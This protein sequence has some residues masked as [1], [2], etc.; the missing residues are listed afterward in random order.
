MSVTATKRDLT[1]VMRV[2]LTAE[3]LLNVFQQGMKLRAEVVSGLP[4]DAVIVRHFFDQ[5]TGFYW[6]TVQSETF[7]SIKTGGVIPVLP[8]VVRDLEPALPSAADLDA[9]AEEAAIRE[10]TEEKAA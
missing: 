7:K 6:L 2:P 8:I 10:A 3:I 4:A 1:K 9:V 5:G